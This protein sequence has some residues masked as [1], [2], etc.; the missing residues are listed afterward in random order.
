MFYFQPY[1][2]KIP[3]LTNTN[4]FQWGWNH[5]PVIGWWQ[6]NWVTSYPPR[7]GLAHLGCSYLDHPDWNSSNS[8][9]PFQHK[10]NPM[11]TPFWERCPLWRF[12]QMSW[13]HQAENYS[14]QKFWEICFF[15]THFSF[16]KFDVIR[17]FNWV[18]HVETQPS[19]NSTPLNY[20]VSTP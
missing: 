15:R 14:F 18:A 8:T 9:L 20:A 16:S 5:Q 10:Q 6:Y 19:P 1:L 2:G 7:A 17:F 11:F 12:F 4:I 13:N 3:I